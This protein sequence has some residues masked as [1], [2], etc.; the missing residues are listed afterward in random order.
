MDNNIIVFDNGGKTA[1]RYTLI[2]PD[3]E[4]HGCSENPYHPQGVGTYNCNVCEARYTDS[5]IHYDNEK[6]RWFPHALKWAYK[7]FLA[8]ARKKDEWLGKEITDQSQLPPAVQKFIAQ[9]HSE[10]IKPREPEVGSE[11]KMITIGLKDLPAFKKAYG[12]AVGLEMPEFTFRG[13]RILL[14][15]AKYIIEYLESVPAYEGTG[16]D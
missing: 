8:E 6:G 15:Y 16:Q 10:M 13:A 11:E 3:G 2:L 9:L 1:D 7:D 5:H 14:S 4:V 12:V